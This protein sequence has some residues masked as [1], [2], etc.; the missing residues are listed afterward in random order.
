MAEQVISIRGMT[1]EDIKA[2][3]D[4][5]REIMGEDRVLTYNDPSRDPA[6][7]YA[8]GGRMGLS[9]IAEADGKV[10]GFILGRITTHPYFLEDTGMII[11]I[12]VI[13]GF[14]HK[15]VATRL[16]KSFKKECNKRE[17]GEVSVLINKEDKAMNSFYK[18]MGFK[19]NNVVELSGSTTECT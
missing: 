11:T 6:K 3:V 7:T 1:E 8:I 16:V 14:Q 9:Q 12:G 4:I 2:V 19:E 18:F 15:G 13:P 10:I 5:N 17:I